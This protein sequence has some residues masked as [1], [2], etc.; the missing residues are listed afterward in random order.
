MG[1][2][3]MNAQMKN[4]TS[5]RAIHNEIRAKSHRGGRA[6]LRTSSG[7]YG[8]GLGLPPISCAQAV[9]H[10]SIS[11]SSAPDLNQHSSYDYKQDIGLKL[12]VL[13]HKV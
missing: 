6:D 8:L 10:L 5:L 9:G 11:A 2:S 4:E 7:R 3:F 12:F 1:K 13:A